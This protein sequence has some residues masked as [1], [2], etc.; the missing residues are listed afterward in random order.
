MRNRVFWLACCVRRR[1]RGRTGAAD[2]T[3]GA[4]L[5]GPEWRHRQGFLTGAKVYFDYINTHGGVNGRENH[6]MW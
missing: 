4:G 3:A 2:C 1:I 5:V 6:P